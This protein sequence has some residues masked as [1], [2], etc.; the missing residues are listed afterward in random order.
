MGEDPDTFYPVGSAGSQ[1]HPVSHRQ[2][3]LKKNLGK[4]RSNS[5]SFGS[6]FPDE[7]AK[8]QREHTPTMS[9]NV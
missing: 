3:D 2:S 6:H 4:F 8:A 5:V 1:N 9:Y 7:E